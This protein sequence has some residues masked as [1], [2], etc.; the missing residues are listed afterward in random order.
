[1]KKHI[2]LAAGLCLFAAGPAVAGP[3]CLQIDSIYNWKA[4][5]NKTLIVEDDWHQKFKVSLMSYC[6]DLAFNE[7][8][9]FRAFGGTRLSCVSAGDDVYTHQLGIGRQRCPVSKVEFYTPEMQKADTDA[10]AAKKAAEE[11]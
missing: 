11:H 10:A 5:D 4:L 3:K 8:I 9:A 1:M 2:L 6:P 7:R